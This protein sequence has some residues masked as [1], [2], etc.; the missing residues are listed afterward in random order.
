MT[1]LKAQT[2]NMQILKYKHLNVTLKLHSC[3]DYGG[4]ILTKCTTH[5][6]L[7]I[8][9]K[10]LSA[11]LRK[12][13]GNCKMTEEPS[14]TIKAA[15][16]TLVKPISCRS[17]WIIDLDYYNDDK[18]KIVNDGE[19]LESRTPTLSSP[20]PDWLPRTQCCSYQQSALPHLLPL[21]GCGRHVR[22][23][24]WRARWE[25]APV[26]CTQTSPG[27]MFPPPTPPL[28]L[29]VMWSQGEADRQQADGCLAQGW[30][31]EN[32]YNGWRNQRQCIYTSAIPFGFFFF[33]PAHFRVQKC[34]NRDEMRTVKV[35]KRLFLPNACSSQ[36]QPTVG[37]SAVRWPWWY[38]V[39]FFM[40]HR[41]KRDAP[42]PRPPNIGTSQPINTPPAKLEV[43]AGRCYCHNLCF[44]VNN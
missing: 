25:D 12:L 10:K 18:K 31:I 15:C 14:V 39:I 13:D 8:Q 24:T 28:R 40:Q 21:D 38:T 11:E 5:F 20:S 42:S 30:Q 1:P 22:C 4:W 6:F 37:V 3:V 36:W 17:R 29:F 19:K 23:Q 44:L 43:H 41:V 26:V 16:C 9:S 34:T 7:C 33:F 2:R 35:L 32:M 27:F